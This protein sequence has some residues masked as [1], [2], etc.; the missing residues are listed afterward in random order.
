ML[1]TQHFPVHSFT[2]EHPEN[3]YK[4]KCLTGHKSIIEKRRRRSL[5]MSSFYIKRYCLMKMEEVKTKSGISGSIL[6]NCLAGKCH[7]PAK[8]EH[9]HERSINVLSVFST[10][11]HCPNQRTNI[12]VDFLLQSR[13]ALKIHNSLRWREFWWWCPLGAGKGHLPARQFIKMDRLI[14]VW[15]HLCFH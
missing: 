7:F 12:F 3:Y 1:T 5:Q 9:L 4:L 2:C 8:D 13:E 14:P 11:W 6:I 10:F 15:A